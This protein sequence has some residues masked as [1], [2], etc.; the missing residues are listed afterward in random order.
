MAGR[1]GNSDCRTAK[2]D[3]ALGHSHHDEHL[4]GCNDAG[5]D[6]SK[7]ENRENGSSEL[8]GAQTERN[9]G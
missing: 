4:R 7:W 1:G 6:G 8:N 2:A 5:Y 9:E 3:A